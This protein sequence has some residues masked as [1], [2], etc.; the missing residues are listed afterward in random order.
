MTVKRGVTKPLTLWSQG[1]S[2]DEAKLFE[3]IRPPIMELCL[4]QLHHQ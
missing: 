2:Q 4:F 3:S 1:G